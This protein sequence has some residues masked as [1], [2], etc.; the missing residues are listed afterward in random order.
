ML[1]AGEIEAYNAKIARST[2][3]RLFTTEKV[4]DLA[5][6]PEQR[7]GSV[8]Q[9]RIWVLAEDKSSRRRIVELKQYAKPAI[10]NYQPQPLVHEWLSDVRRAFWPGLDGSAYDLVELAGAG[11]FWIRE[12]H[13][14]LI[15][16]PYSSKK[17]SDIAFLEALA[18]YD[19]NVLGL[20][21]G[22]QAQAAPYRAIV[23]RDTEAFHD[24]TE[25][26]AKAYLEVARESFHDK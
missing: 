2:I 11:L 4:I 10:A 18:I 23:E 3:E 22:R 25:A 24:A 12:K 16:L 8:D 26:V 21:H 19:A 13:V 7:G 20:A 1:K 14:S 9:L 17:S 6:R 15:D 5:M